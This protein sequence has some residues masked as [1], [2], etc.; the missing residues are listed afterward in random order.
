MSNPEDRVD[1]AVRARIEDVVDALAD[2][3]V[4]FAAD[5]VRVRS[6]PGDEA[7]A[8][9]LVRERLEAL[10]LQIDE[11]NA[12]DVAG[13]RNHP[14][15]V[16]PSAPYDDRPNLVATREGVGAGRSLLFNGHVDVVPE[17]DREAWTFD[18]FAGTV[19]DGQL[20]GRGAS[21]MKGG[22]A[23]MVYALYALEHAGIDLQG[24][25]TVAS[26]IEEEPGGAGGTLATVLD[27]VVADAVVI[28]EPTDFD[29]W[30]AN[31]GVSNFRVTVEGKG[32]H[33]AETDAG[34]NAMS[35]LV[36]I[37]RALEALHDHRKTTVHDPL[38]EERHEHTV[39]LNLGRVRAGEW[40]SSVPD[41]AI[42]EARIS[43]APSETREE[44]RE[45]VESTVREAA[46]GDA[47]LEDHPPS[48][49]WY[50]WR[51]SS[52]KIDPDE[53]IVET[54]QSVAANA[55]GRESHAIGFPG[56]IDTRFY[57][58][59]A[60]TPAVCFGPGAYNIHG[61]DEHLPVEELF[62][63]TLALALVAMEWCGYEV[64]A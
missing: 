14:E 30:I 17:G 16:E 13:L 50:G 25:L 59:D 38:F 34:V 52:A 46:A 43:H 57:V 5:L 31:D 10:D 55:L 6:V 64:R 58:N 47:W 62:E 53:P 12:A 35:K 39:S 29:L 40:A 7:A 41:E 63:I 20:R 4:A 54:V 56:G 9:A 15:Y 61:T 36:P 27:G 3:L 24:D 26:V 42:L 37:Y 21:D 8:Q 18:P 48:V 44:L 11:V 60:D 33:A 45:S 19:A 23:A 2:E 49:E 22:V 51:G 28:P 32:A 1:P